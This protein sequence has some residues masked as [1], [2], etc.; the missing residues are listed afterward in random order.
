MEQNCVAVSRMNQFAALVTELASKL[1]CAVAS[2]KNHPALAA[3]TKLKRGAGL[4]PEEVDKLF[5]E[6]YVR[7]KTALVGA[8]QPSFVQGEINTANKNK[9]KFM[10]CGLD[11][12]KT[13]LLQQIKP[14]E[15]A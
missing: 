6:D 2:A 15:L 13:C 8:F 11:P 10:N 5:T 12:M 1:G 14:P 9:N 4:P 7:L 3:L